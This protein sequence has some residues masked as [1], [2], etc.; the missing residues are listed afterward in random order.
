MGSVLG[1]DIDLRLFLNR[2]KYAFAVVDK[3]KKSLQFFD[4]HGDAVHKVFLLSAS[5]NEREFFDLIS[6][7]TDK[8]PVVDIEITPR[9][10]LLSEPIHSASDLAAFR[11]AWDEMQDTHEFYTL[12]QR[13]RLGRTEALKLAGE[14]RA[15][16]LSVCS[17]RRLLE[18]ASNSQTAIMVF[19]GNPGC[20]QIHTGLIRTVTTDKGWLNV[21][22]PDFSLHICEPLIGSVW[23]VRK[24]TRDGV[25]TS[26]EMYN[27][28]G[29]NQALFFG[30]RKPHSPE[31]TDWRNILIQ[32]EQDSVS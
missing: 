2:W 17:V 22:D 12:L 3:E 25:V 8:R 14:P 1:A 7:V 9:K 18:I 5:S 28:R 13:F 27:T 21:L 32:L 15:V 20:I 19:V 6:G 23:I 26:V 10:Q 11:K 31:S 4:V 24:P 16:Q 30:K 29:E